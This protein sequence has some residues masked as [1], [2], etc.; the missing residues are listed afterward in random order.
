MGVDHAVKLG[1][2]QPLFFQLHRQHSTANINANQI[3][4]YLVCDRHGQSDHA[5]LSGVYIRHDPDFAVLR[6]GLI[7]KCTD[8]F[9]C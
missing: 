7:A 9:F 8:L 1:K 2:V 3:G 6:L 5:S 4:N